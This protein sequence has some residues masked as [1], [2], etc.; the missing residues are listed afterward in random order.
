MK[1]RV[2]TWFLRKPGS[3]QPQSQAG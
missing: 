1:G 2:S 3:V